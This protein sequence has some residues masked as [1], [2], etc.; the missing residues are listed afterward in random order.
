MDNGDLRPRD[1]GCDQ[2]RER[3]SV[4]VG[5]DSSGPRIHVCDRS[6]AYSVEQFSEIPCRFFTADVLHVGA[7]HNLVCDDFTIEE[8]DTVCLGSSNVQA[9]DTACNRP[10]RAAVCVYWIRFWETV[11]TVHLN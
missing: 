3:G 10:G 4:V 7:A 2:R 8:A 6:A 9:D 5:V 1:V 11:C